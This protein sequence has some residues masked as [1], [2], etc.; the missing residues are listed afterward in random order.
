MEGRYRHPSLEALWLVNGSYLRKQQTVFGLG[1]PGQSPAAGGA[2]D[3]A[4]GLGVVQLDRGVV[5]SAGAGLGAVSL[6][7]VVQEEGRAV[8]R[9]HAQHAAPCQLGGAIPGGAPGKQCAQETSCPSDRFRQPNRLTAHRQASHAAL[10]QQTG[11]KPLQANNAGGSRNA[12][13]LCET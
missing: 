8:V 2:A 7:T 9:R 10:R 1:R 3:G 4:D 6:P 13:Y 12:L 5:S 11:T